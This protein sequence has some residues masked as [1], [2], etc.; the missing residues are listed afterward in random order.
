M[1]DKDLSDIFLTLVRVGIGHDIITLKQ[2]ADWQSIIA[3]ADK[4]GLSA[5]VLNGLNGLPGSYRPSKNLLLHWIG[6]V[7]QG[8][9]QRF[10]QYEK[11]IADLADF[12]NSHGY[13]MMVLKGY[14]CS[15][16]W[17]K[18]EYRPCGDI[19]IW[20][21][22]EYKSADALLVKENG[23]TIDNSHHHHTVF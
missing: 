3:L 10:A 15:L 21:F 22:G 23:I 5:I 14:A 2:E 7:L 20:Q 11:A 19:D 17:P 1:Q 18:P 9:E 13:K 16:D 6:E 8:Y 4:Q 12:Y